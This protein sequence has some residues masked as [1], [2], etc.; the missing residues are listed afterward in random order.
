M[1]TFDT[2]ILAAYESGLV[3]E[4]IALAYASQ[5]SAITRGIDRIKNA[6]GEKTTPIEG[7][8]LDRD[9]EKRMA[10]TGR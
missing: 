4:E 5:R 2:A 9:Y 3:N 8:D 6:R 1:Q 7:L 10:Q